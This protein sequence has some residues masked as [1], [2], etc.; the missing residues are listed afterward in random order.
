MIPGVGCGA[1]GWHQSVSYTEPRPRIP[2]RAPG[3]SAPSP[4]TSKTPL[5]L[6]LCLCFQLL[7]KRHV[8]HAYPA[9]LS[10][11]ALHWGHCCP[12]RLLTHLDERQRLPETGM[13][14]SPGRAVSPLQAARPLAAAC[15]PW[16]PGTPGEPGRA[17]VGWRGASG[18]VAIHFPSGRIL[19]SAL[20]SKRL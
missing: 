8:L 7:S 16:R 13:R 2:L 18:A 3:C 5:C 14:G 6:C 4:P 1:L 17:A 20:L 10:D 9:S 15:V 12:F 11:V 19:G